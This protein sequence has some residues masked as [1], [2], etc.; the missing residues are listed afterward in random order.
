MHKCNKYTNV[1]NE[2]T[3]V[4]CK[5]DDVDLMGKGTGGDV[6]TVT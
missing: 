6:T 3:R 1:M 5:S 4:I 2:R